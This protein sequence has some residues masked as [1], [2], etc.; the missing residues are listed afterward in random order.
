MLRDLN[1]KLLDM[2]PYNPL[3]VEKARRVGYDISYFRET[4]MTSQE[5]SAAACYFD[6]FEFD[7]FTI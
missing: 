3:W 6:D 7:T 1:V 2:L 4:W 5:K